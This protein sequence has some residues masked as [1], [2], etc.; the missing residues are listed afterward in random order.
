MR[1]RWFWFYSS[2]KSS[3]VEIAGP[4]PDLETLVP[5]STVKIV[6]SQ[7]LCVLRLSKPET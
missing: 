1:K 3:M 4:E 2:L 5:L 7:A 6:L